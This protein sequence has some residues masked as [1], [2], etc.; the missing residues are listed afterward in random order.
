MSARHTAI[1]FIT[2]AGTLF[3]TLFLV[4]VLLAAIPAHK[5]HPPQTSAAQ[6]SQPNQTNDERTGKAAAEH[7]MVSGAHDAH[8]LH[9]AYSHDHASSTRP[10]ATCNAP[11]NNPQ[12]IA[13]GNRKIYIRII[14]LP[15][16]R[17]SRF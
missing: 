15:S 16:T 10:R 9:T 12:A 6:E 11:I 14:P 1:H 13:Q 2:K 8:H 3:A 5:S 7:D 17:A 4:G